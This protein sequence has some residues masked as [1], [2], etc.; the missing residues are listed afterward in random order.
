MSW[1]KYCGRQLYTVFCVSSPSAP[2]FNIPYSMSQTWINSL[3][4]CGND[5]LHRAQPSLLNTW[6]RFARKWS[7]NRC[8]LLPILWR[9]HVLLFV[10]C[11]G[12]CP[13]VHLVLQDQ[14][15]H[16]ALLWVYMLGYWFVKGEKNIFHNNPHH[17]DIF[18]T[19]LLLYVSATIPHAFIWDTLLYR[20]YPIHCVRL[21]V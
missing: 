7:W 15:D 21:P 12:M 8:P 2:S 3:D 16:P 17:K 14:K 6:L 10:H 5:L 20:I 13:W 4:G 9:G 18:E 11:M 1:G 19:K